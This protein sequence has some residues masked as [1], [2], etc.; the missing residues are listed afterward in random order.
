[1][2]RKHSKP[3]A[4]PQGAPSP[5]ATVRITEKAPDADQ[6]LPHLIKDPALLSRF[7]QASVKHIARRLE[8]TPLI[9]KAKKRA[10]I[11]KH[12]IVEANQKRQREAAGKYEKIRKFARQ[13][14]DDDPKLQRARTN[15]LAIKI[16]KQRPEWSERTIRRA[17]APKK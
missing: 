14:I 3:P 9:Q 7:V 2:K 6:L 13:I 10:E 5:L 12:T 8:D 16:H 1:M 4:A 15:R 11:E 17:L